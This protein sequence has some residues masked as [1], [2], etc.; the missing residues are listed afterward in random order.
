MRRSFR[1]RLKRVLIRIT[2]VFLKYVAAPVVLLALVLLFVPQARAGFHTVLFVT[3]TLDLPVKPQSWFTREPVRHEAVYGS[4][5]ASDVA[6]VYR[7]PG[8]SRRA[9]VLLSI[10][11]GQTGLGDETVTNLGYALARAG[12]VTMLHWSPDLGRDA[13]IQLDDPDKLVRAFEYLAAQVYVDP[14]RVGLGGF[15][16]GGSFAMVAAAD[17][18][19]RDDVH[20]IN[21]FGPYFDLE[22]LLLEA[23]SRSVVE[24]G[25]RTPWEPHSL[26]MRVLGHEL[27]ETVDDPED[28]RVL[29]R[30]YLDDMQA[31]LAELQGLSQR[32]RIVARMLDGVTPQEAD[33][34]Y[35]ALPPDFREGLA[36]IS[37]SNHIEEMPARI[38]VMHDRY[39]RH[40][41]VGESRR[42]VEAV[43][44]RDDFR[45]TEFLTFNHT[46]PGEG[47]LWDRLAQAFRLSRHMYDLIRIAV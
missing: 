11:A 44:D 34:L 7:P 2:F 22:T 46:I 27:I 21:A 17:S 32:G 3:Q 29:T 20:F 30:H 25:E 42:L 45:Y 38:L 8:D 23:V 15:S 5:E 16:V 6:D 41:P 31:T 47:G 26:T 28:A 1:A 36:E 37:P 43:G 35:A 4:F 40:V 19:I 9:A 18:R 33:E 39:D 14:E 13:D 24:N 12:F 10:G